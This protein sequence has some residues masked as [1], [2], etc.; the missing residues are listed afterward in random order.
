MYIQGDQTN[1]R[2]NRPKCSPIHFFRNLYKKSD[3]WEKVAKHFWADS[4]ISKKLPEEDNRS[5]EENSPNLVT[6]HMYIIYMLRAQ[7]KDSGART[8]T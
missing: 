4:V 3:L 2:K 6:L 5:I 8:Q 7:L 1:V